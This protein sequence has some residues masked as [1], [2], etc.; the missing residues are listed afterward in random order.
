MR[1]QRF[2]PI[3]EVQSDL[4]GQ[5]YNYASDC[6]SCGRRVFTVTDENRKNDEP[7]PRGFAGTSY[8][9][10]TLEEFPRV[11]FCWDCLN[12]H[13]SEGESTCRNI[14]T[15]RAQAIASC[16]FCEALTYLEHK[17]E[18]PVSAVCKAHVGRWIL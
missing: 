13:G 10:A 5:V 6:A 4:F 15:F 7:D 16:S 9:L 14:A 18:N 12:E 2:D 8:S 11:A 1:K 17:N 3:R